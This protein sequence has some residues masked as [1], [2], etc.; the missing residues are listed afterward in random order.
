[1]NVNPACCDVCTAGEVPDPK[2]DLLVATSL[3]HIRKPKT[4]HLI[5]NT[6]ME[7]FIGGERKTHD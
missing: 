6:D 4:V 3:K 7:N 2:L 5:I 1:M